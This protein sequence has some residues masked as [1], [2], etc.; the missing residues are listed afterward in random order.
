M[1]VR[2]PRGIIC[3]WTGS[4][5]NIPL[6]WGLCDGTAGTPDLQDRFIIGAGDSFNP[7]DTGGANLHKHDFAGDGHQH[8]M[9]LGT[10]LL[11]GTDYEWFSTI[12]TVTGESDWASTL[13]PYYALCYIM[14]L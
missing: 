10:G 9:S 14:R 5:A 1:G 11:Y 2:I 7:R 8:S 3:C 12:E 6:G 13:P 4:V